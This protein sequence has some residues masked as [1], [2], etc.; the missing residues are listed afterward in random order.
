MAKKNKN[1]TFYII[2]GF[3]ILLIVL[4]VAYFILNK[5]NKNT[6]SS[7]SDNPTVK[8]DSP[9]ITNNIGDKNKTWS[10]I[11]SYGKQYNN[12]ITYLYKTGNIWILGDRI[13]LD[14]SPSKDGKSFTI[15]SIID[16]LNSGIKVDDIFIFY[17]E[18][19]CYRCVRDEKIILFPTIC[20]PKLPLVLSINVLQSFTGTN[21]FIDL[22]KL[23]SDTKNIIAVDWGDGSVI[24]TDLKH[25]YSTPGTYNIKI[26]GNLKSLD[27]TDFIKPFKGTTPLSDYSDM[28]KIGIGSF[29][30]SYNT[31]ENINFNISTDITNIPLSL[32]PNVTKLSFMGSKSICDI[33]NLNVSRITDMSSMF[34]VSLLSTFTSF[35]QDLSN[36]D[37]SNVQNM[38][39]M[40]SG[41][42]S[43]NQPLN[44]WDVSNVQNMIGMF[45]Y[46][47]SFNQPLNNWDVSKVQNM[48]NM[49]V[50]CINFNQDLSNWDVSN[51]SYMTNIFYNCTN[52]NQP[53]DNWNVKNVIY[54]NYMFY[55][56]QNFNKPL[57][58]GNKV[59]KVQNMSNMFHACTSFNQDLSDW[60]VYKVQ[61]MTGMFSNCT[62]FNQP[63][64]NWDVS[65]VQNM[66]EMFYSC[67]N[68]NKPLN[69]WNVS[70]VTNMVNMFYACTSFN[71]PLDNW[72]VSKVQNMS[73]IFSNCTSFNQPLDMWD[74][75]KV[76]NMGGM[77][78]N[79][80]MFNQDLNN[81]DVSNVTNM[82]QMLLNCINFNKSLC[83][84]VKKVK[85]IDIL[86][87]DDYL[88]NQGMI[89][90]GR[91]AVPPNGYKKIWDFNTDEYSF[92]LT[93]FTNGKFL[94]RYIT[95]SLDLGPYN[96]KWTNS[97]MNFISDN[98]PFSITFDQNDGDSISDGS[99]DQY[100]IDNVPIHP[101]LKPEF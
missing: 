57:N 23:Y 45:D 55:N 58:W 33:T 65:N 48:S 81:W 76:Q 49:F 36:W 73:D 1:N 97:T 62:M 2:I 100:K 32:P 96:I 14:I 24:P 82:D 31:L 66:N 5:N 12:Y 25:Q 59:S 95:I 74:V 63:L 54:T 91:P 11:T 52:F 7:S 41:C 51:V 35:N 92:L 34:S 42:T 53:L 94:L 39:G 21:Y 30:S 50:N 18:N 98:K 10:L 86:Y 89:C 37:V 84:L 72:N 68:F 93:M 6:T 75:S 99:F 4:I 67:T 9:L 38:N 71:Q 80:T 87:N 101:V 78:S 3:I 60:N 13:Q 20:F 27:F 79:C 40:F 90:N 8:C 46:C 64:N 29:G 56:C 69:N 16:S 15:K 47:N 44:N 77:F 61:N 70:N 88:R 83:P 26:Y 22:S 85:N 28:F 43:F 17:Q 19:N